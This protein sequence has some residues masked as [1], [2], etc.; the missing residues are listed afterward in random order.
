MEKL[1]VIVQ[2]QRE[3]VVHSGQMFQ[4][5]LGRTEAQRRVFRHLFQQ[6]RPKRAAGRRVV[7]RNTQSSAHTAGAADCAVKPS[8]MHHLEDRPNTFALFKKGVGGGGE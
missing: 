4:T 5:S 2:G 3:V 8:V 6:G 1:A 7:Q